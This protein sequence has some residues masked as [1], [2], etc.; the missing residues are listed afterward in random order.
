[1]FVRENLALYCMFRSV[2]GCNI[3]P[4]F[5]GIKVRF[6]SSL[7]SIAKAQTKALLQ[8]QCLLVDEHDHITGTASKLDC[9]IWNPALQNSPLH[10]AFSLFLFNSRSELL[11]QQRSDQKVT[12]PGHYTNSCCSHPLDVAEERSGV[13]GAVIAARRRVQHELGIPEQQTDPSEYQFLTRILYNGRVE[14]SPFAENE[15]DYILFLQKDIPLLPNPDEVKHVEYVARDHIHEYL[16]TLQQEGVLLTP[17][18]ALIMKHFLPHWW[19]NLDRL[20]D[21]MDRDTI[22]RL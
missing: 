15:L 8:E 3:S 20:Q 4:S 7:E 11:L 9:H 1:M 14:G 13:E 6:S 12:F 5:H 22:H 21:C 18:F 17:W 10:R 19:D 16:A 2:A